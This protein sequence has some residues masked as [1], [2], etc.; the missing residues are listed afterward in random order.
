MLGMLPAHKRF[1][2][3]DAVAGHIQLRLVVHTQFPALHGAAQ[4]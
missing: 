2:A 3:D 4:L 1:C